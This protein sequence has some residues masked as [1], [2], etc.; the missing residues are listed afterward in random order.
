MEHVSE[1]SYI[2]QTLVKNSDQGSSQPAV[3]YKHDTS[4]QVCIA[5]RVFPRPFTHGGTSAGGQS[6][7]GGDS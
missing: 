5:S 4:A 1:Q 3:I 7:N 2:K 6:V